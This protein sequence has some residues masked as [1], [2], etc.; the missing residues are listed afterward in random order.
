MWKCL[1]CGEVHKEGYICDCGWNRTKDYLHYYTLCP[2]GTKEKGAWEKIVFDSKFDFRKGQE[3]QEKGCLKE[4]VAYYQKAADKNDVDAMIHLGYCFWK[5][6]GTERNLYKAMGLYCKV[7]DTG[8][9]D[10]SKNMDKIYEE[11]K[12]SRKIWGTLRNDYFKVIEDKIERSQIQNIIIED[13]LQVDDMCW[14]SIEKIYDVS[15]E[16]NGSIKMW[17]LKNEEGFN[18]H[19]GGASGIVA[20]KVSSY[21][22]CGYT[23]LKKI[24]F[25]SNFDTQNVN[26]MRGMFYNCKQLEK[27]DVSNFDT[28]NVSDMSSMFQN[29]EQLKELDVSNFDTQ[30][31]SDM[32]LMFLGCKQ[33]KKLDVS[34]F[35]T[36][37]VSDMRSM[38][39]NCKQLKKLDVS[40]FD[41]RN[42]SDM[43]LMFYDCE[44][45]EMLNVSG[46]ETQ[47]V[48]DMHRMFESCKQLKKLDVSNFDTRNVCNMSRML[49][50]CNYLNSFRGID[51]LRKKAR[52]ISQSRG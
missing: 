8:T 27:L 26:D 44:Q 49:Y 40:K 5:G 48:R 33:L 42:V 14:N 32:S 15:K 9:K 12:A 50:Y 31:V 28:K 34:N 30:N 3:Y 39:E 13:T 46:F 37:N 4:A 22:F 7:M 52:L 45:L 17:L 51:Q 10:V 6:L 25:E 20:P 1:F 43:S 11:I 18:L 35:N 21:L 41:T 38:F 29:C 19:I 36:Q 23:N 24:I 47:N 16:K 2:V